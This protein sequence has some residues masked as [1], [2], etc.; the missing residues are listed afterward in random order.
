MTKTKSV[1]GGVLCIVGAVMAFFAT[2]Q[3]FVCAVMTD[4]AKSVT[5][6]NT[7]GLYSVLTWACGIGSFVC[8]IVGAVMSFKNSFVGGILGAIAAV[9]I[10]IPYVIIGAALDYWQSWTAIIAMILLAVG[11]VL[12]FVVKTPIAGQNPPPAAP[13]DNNTPNA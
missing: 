6:G 10:F 13:T 2:I 3:L 12:A 5:E 11:A 9:L 4:V 1:A 8:A 7:S